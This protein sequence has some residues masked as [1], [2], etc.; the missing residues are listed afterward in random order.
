VLQG[1]EA[2][3][4]QP[5]PQQLL[6]RRQEA[7][8]EA[9]LADFL[10]DGPSGGGGGGDDWRAE[11]RSITG[12][13]PSRWACINLL[14]LKRNGT[15]LV[16]LQLRSIAGCDSSRSASIVVFYSRQYNTVVYLELAA[17][18]GGP[19][20]APYL[21]ATHPGEHTCTALY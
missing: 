18:T 19:S 1:S 13:D 11:L 15:Q 5:H 20:C 3:P 16:G 21:A 4:R 17:P 7:E 14:A 6:R 8:E 12:Y 2:K 9:E 10:D